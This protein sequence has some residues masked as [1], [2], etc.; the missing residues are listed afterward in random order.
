MSDNIKHPYCRAENQ[1]ELIDKTVSRYNLPK[2]E[3]MTIHF[4]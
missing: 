3:D 1:F 4:I 2:D